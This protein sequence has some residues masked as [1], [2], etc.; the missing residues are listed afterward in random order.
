MPYNGCIS[1]LRGAC[2]ER[3]RNGQ[4]TAGLVL[5]ILSIP[6]VIVPLLGLILGILGIIF[7]TLGLK[8][9][10]RT[11]SMWGLGLGIVGVVL[12]LALVIL[13]AV[14]VANHAVHP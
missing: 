8:S 3:S 7:G 12:A 4:A 14:L 10:L 11:R 1:V 5:G 6:F 9:S 13:G 2:M